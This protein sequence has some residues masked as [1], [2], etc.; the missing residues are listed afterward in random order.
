MNASAK[1]FEPDEQSAPFGT[2][3][4]RSMRPVWLLTTLLAVWV[5]VLGWMAAQRILAG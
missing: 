1:R 3:P 2:L 5:A 4:R